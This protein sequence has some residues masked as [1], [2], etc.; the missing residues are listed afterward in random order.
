M[1][2][3]VLALVALLGGCGG[4][5][6]LSSD[7]RSYADGTRDD[8]PRFIAARALRDAFTGVSTAAGGLDTCDDLGCRADKGLALRQAAEAGVAQ[9]TAL[10]TRPLPECYVKA[11]D[12]ATRALDAYRRAGIA[13]G[14]I[15]PDGTESALTRAGRFEA[16]VTR[17]IAGC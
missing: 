13:F 16:G 1:G 4:G 2:A 6:D 3:T 5:D 7:D 8:A 11:V 9:L 12:Q 17:S 14:R 15:H 10:D